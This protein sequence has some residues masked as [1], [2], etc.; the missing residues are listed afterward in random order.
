[1]S[2]STQRQRKEVIRQILQRVDERK[3]LGERTVKRQVASLHEMAVSSFGDW[4]IALSHAGIKARRTGLLYAHDAADC[5]RIIRRLCHE[6]RS[7]K[8][9][10]VRRRQSPLYKAALKFF[11]SWLAAVE[12]AG[13]NSAQVNPHAGWDRERIIEA[14]LLRA[15]ERRALGSTK[16]RP[17]SL[18][19]AA[20]R[21]FGSWDGALCA[22]DLDPSDYIGRR[23]LAVP[24][25]EKQKWNRHEVLKAI[26]RRQFLGLPLDHDSVCR[27]YRPL[28]N[29]ATSYFGGWPSALNAAGTD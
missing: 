29:A 23:I 11:G 4:H 25:Q 27:D 26:R 18:K 24:E 19:A 1:M 15:V 8:T 20:I 14:I 28:V 7:L 16:V 9:K 12:A 22:A 3:S 5:I 6:G 2:P 10:H 21:E 17:Y 13:I